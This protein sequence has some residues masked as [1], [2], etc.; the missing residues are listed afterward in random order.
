MTD[1]NVQFQS[2]LNGMF[3]IYQTRRQIMDPRF[4]TTGK[5][6]DGSGTDGTRAG[7]AVADRGAGAVG[8]SGGDGRD[9]T[10]DYGA[11]HDSVSFASTR[12]SLIVRPE[13]MAAV[14]MGVN[15]PV[16]FDRDASTGR[17]SGRDEIWLRW[18]YILHPRGYGWVGDTGSFARNDDV[19]VSL[20]SRDSADAKAYGGSAA[21]NRGYSS[22]SNWT[23]LDK[24]GLLR[25]LPVFH[26]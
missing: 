1:G 5:F 19:A 16:E 22:G 10:V 6:E 18:G 9:G 4:V 23:R 2:A 17:G 20:D 11:T 15:R 3:R 24:P 13:A 21:Q 7:A 14:P 26:S 8:T 12:T 25:I